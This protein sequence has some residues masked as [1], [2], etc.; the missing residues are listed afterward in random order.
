MSNDDA[1]SITAQS[2]G[3]RMLSL[4]DKLKQF[5]PATHGGEAMASKPAGVEI[6]AYRHRGQIA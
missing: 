1:G 6:T 2:I 3:P 5:D 4:A